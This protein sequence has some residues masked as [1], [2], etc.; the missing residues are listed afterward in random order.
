MPGY[1][2]LQ[3]KM[4]WE[5]VTGAP[6]WELGFHTKQTLTL[7][8]QGSTSTYNNTPLDTNTFMQSFIHHRPALL[9]KYIVLST[10][11]TT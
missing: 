2:V 11:K 4:S 6:I 9:T 3:I 5:E 10:Q 8:Y 1:K 7:Q